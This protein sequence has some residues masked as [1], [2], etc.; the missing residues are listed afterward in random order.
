[1]AENIA[2]KFAAAKLSL[3]ADSDSQVRLAAIRAF[4]ADKI[5][6]HVAGSLV[7]A[8]PK[9]DDDFQRSAAL[10]ALAQNSAASI[11]AV[12]GSGDASLAP[13]AGQLAQ[14]TAEKNDAA[15]AAK[16]VVLL[17]AQPAVADALKRSIL[18]T[19]GKS[20]KADPEMTPELSSALGKLLASGASGSALP[21][22]ARW[23]KAG[24][25]KSEVQKLTGTLLAQLADAKAADEARINAAGSLIGLRSTNA[26][27]LPAVIS[28]L[29][30]DGSAPFKRQLIV[31]LGETG[32]AGV[33]KALAANFGKLPADSQTAAFDTVLKRSE[34][35]LAFLDAVGTKQIDA[36][37]LGPANAARLRTHPD[38]AVSK[39]ATQMLDELNPLAKAKK[40]AIAKLLPAVE[41]PGDA[42]KG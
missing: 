8:W 5:D 2:K 39:R 13:L 11:A 38:R 12:L 42:A 20:L 17:A 41:Q 31:A 4:S 16:L 33:G 29:G 30:K 15:G 26:E 19:L 6:E 23:D 1:M 14:A 7:T 34:W 40:D 9:F 35:A 3:L 24:A 25:L 22:A 28:Q 32:D 37:T 21:L 36:L 18:D 27:I 10:G